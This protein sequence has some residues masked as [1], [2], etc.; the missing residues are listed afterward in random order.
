M[1]ALHHSDYLQLAA[2]LARTQW[3]TEHVTSVEVIRPIGASTFARATADEFETTVLTVSCVDP[4]GSSPWETFGPLQWLE[5]TVYDAQGYPTA[6]FRNAR[7]DE[8]RTA[9]L[10]RLSLWKEKDNASDSPAAGPDRSTVA[11]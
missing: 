7:G 1:K 3:P 8:A 5:A 9:M 6:Y 10:D 4:D 2:D 11:V